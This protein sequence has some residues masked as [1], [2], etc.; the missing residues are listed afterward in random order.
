MSGVELSINTIAAVG[1]L[2]SGVIMLIT[3]VRVITKL[4]IKEQVIYGNEATIQYEK[5]IK[6]N[7]LKEGHNGHMCKPYLYQGG[8]IIVPRLQIER[9]V[10][11]PIIMD[12]NLKKYKQTVLYFDKDKNVTTWYLK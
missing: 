5:M 9:F 2:L 8:N 10:Y 6:D 12:A 3:F 1:S 4:Q 7:K 11:N